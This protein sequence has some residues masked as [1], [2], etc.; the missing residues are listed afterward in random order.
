M[1]TGAR[2]RYL[3]QRLEH[4]FVMI[5]LCFNS[6][7]ISFGGISVTLGSLSKYD[8]ILVIVP[9]EKKEYCLV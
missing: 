2:H 6:R 9:T 5:P 4:A 8:K 7:E 1:D 3:I